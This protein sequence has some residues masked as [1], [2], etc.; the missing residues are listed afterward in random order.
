MNLLATTRQT[1]G[2]AVAL[3]LVVLPHGGQRGA[4]RNAWTAMVA[5]T[6]QARIRGEA[7]FAV[8]RAAANSARRIANTLQRAN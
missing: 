3:S 5:G 4:R 8:D 2:L 6:A 7:Q 1:L